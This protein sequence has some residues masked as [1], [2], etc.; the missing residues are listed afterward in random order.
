M[1]TVMSRRQQS[2]NLAKNPYVSFEKPTIDEDGLLWNEWKIGVYGL[3]FSLIVLTVKFFATYRGS[4]EKAFLEPKL[5]QQVLIEDGHE[6]FTYSWKTVVK[7]SSVW[8]PVLCG[9]LTTYFTWT[10]VYLDSKIPG[11]N[12]PSPLSPQKY[13]LQSGYTFHLSYVFAIVVGIWV[14]IYL[15]CRGAS[16]QF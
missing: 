6:M 1:R 11:V 9:L 8:F 12:P 3:I 7:Y 4:F 5:I 15:F 10:I 14:A 2:E 13:K 16:I